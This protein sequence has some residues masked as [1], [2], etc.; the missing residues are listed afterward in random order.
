MFV[1][2]CISAATAVS[3]VFLVAQRRTFVHDG[4]RLF[5]KFIAYGFY[6][7]VAIVLAS[8]AV[9]GLTHHVFDPI[10]LAGSNLLMQSAG[11]DEQLALASV[12]AKLT[13]T[14]FTLYANYLF[15]S[16]LMEGRTSFR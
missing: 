7:V 12:F 9:A 1:S 15:M 5:G 4:S 2:N 6:N 13:V 8:F 3:F 14:P 10:V 16:R 11:T